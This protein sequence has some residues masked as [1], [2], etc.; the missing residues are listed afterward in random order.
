MAVMCEK[1]GPRQKKFGQGPEKCFSIAVP[2]DLRKKWLLV[3]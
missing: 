3:K 1:F 2:S